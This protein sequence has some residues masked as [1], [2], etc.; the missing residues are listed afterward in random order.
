LGRVGF[1]L[2]PHKMATAAGAKIARKSLTA[3]VD[4]YEMRE[5]LKTVMP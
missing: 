4:V 3:G 2:N 1:E 5:W